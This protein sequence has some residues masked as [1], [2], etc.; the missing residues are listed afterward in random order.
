MLIPL[1]GQKQLDTFLFSKDFAHTEMV[2]VTSLL[3][4]LPPSPK[5]ERDS[6]AVGIQTLA[7]ATVSSTI[8]APAKDKM[9]KA[10][11]APVI[12]KAKGA[13]N[14]KPCEIQDETIAA[15][16]RRFKV[17]P[18]GRIGDSPRHIPYSSD[19]KSFHQKT[20]RD[21]FESNN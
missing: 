7:S 16:H 3:N 8:P 14:Y 1:D 17:E 10:V 19:K 15:E 5:N 21:A 11:T 2:S 6:V 4:P 13:I 9:S 18:I 12:G 20:G